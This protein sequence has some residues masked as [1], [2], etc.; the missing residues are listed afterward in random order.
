MSIMREQQEMTAHCL[1]QYGNLGLSN[2]ATG[3]EKEIKD[4]P[5]WKHAMAC[6]RKQTFL[7]VRVVKHWNKQ[8]RNLCHLLSDME[9]PTRSTSEKSALADSVFNGEIG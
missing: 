4:V 1:F 3:D 6:R 9:N 7:S 5:L 8:P 2:E